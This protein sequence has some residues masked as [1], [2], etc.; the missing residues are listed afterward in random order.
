[1][2]V[3]I[4]RRLNHFLVRE[5]AFHDERTAACT[6]ARTQIG[7]AN[8]ALEGVGQSCGIARRNDESV[9][10]FMAHSMAELPQMTRGVGLGVW[11]AIEQ[12]HSVATA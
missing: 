8:Q 9:L 6:V 7:I 2:L 10:I 5:P 4:E 12:F 1:M 3:E 11:S